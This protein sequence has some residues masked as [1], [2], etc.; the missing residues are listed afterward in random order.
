MTLTEFDVM[1]SK[2]ALKRKGVSEPTN[3]QI[4]ME[5]IRETRDSILLQSDWMGNSDV[6]MSED[7]KTYRQA[8]RDLPAKST[9]SLDKNG[10][11]TGV[12]WP[13]KPE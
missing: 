12:E 7:W 13:T 1:R 11:L 6:T 8:L 9:P 3:A 5:F 10:N 2:I 4:A